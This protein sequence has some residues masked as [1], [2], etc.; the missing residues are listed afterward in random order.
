MGESG[1]GSVREVLKRQS[2]L[3]LIVRI[4][5]CLICKASLLIRYSYVELS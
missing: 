1:T 2:P 4:T 3:A 5:Y